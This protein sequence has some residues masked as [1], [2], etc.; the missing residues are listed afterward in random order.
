MLSFM[1]RPRGFYRDIVL[2]A[3]P[4][5]IQNLI[6]SSMSLL[7]TVMVGVLGELPLAAVALAN[8]PCF[9][10][11]FVIFGIQSGCSVLIS[12][13]WGKGD[14][15]AINRVLGMG[16]YSACSATLVFALATALFP[17]PFMSLFG[18]DQVVAE[19]AAEYIRIIGFSYFADSFV[20]IYIAAHRSMENPRLG[21]YILAA[22]VASNTFLN[23]ALIFGRFGAPAFGVAG[24]ALA[25]LLSRC[26]GLLLALGHFFLSFF[27]QDG[28]PVAGQESPNF[29]RPRGES[30]FFLL[31]FLERKRRGKRFRPDLAA[32]L[33][34]GGPMA[35]QFFRCSAPVVFNET[36]WGLGTALYATIMGH[37]EGS[38]EIL[39]AYAIAGNIERLCTVAIFAL[40]GTSAVIVGREIGAGKDRRTVYEV[41]ACLNLLTALTG[42]VLSLLLLV[43]LRLVIIPYLYPVFS[44][45][46]RSA[47]IATVML[48]VIFA[49]QT[50]RGF[51]TTN[52]VGV[53]RG[54]G[55]VRAAALIDTVPLWCVSLPLAALAGLA[56]RLDILWVY[57][58]I[59]TEGLAKLAL[60]VGRLRSG[61]WINDLTRK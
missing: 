46:P 15:D 8:I 60:G 52:I 57:L 11:T 41:G 10:A 18:N 23:W 44:L 35:L 2:L 28:V 24:A 17:L 19:L 27:Q 37:M 20:Q 53:L 5:L 32:L 29:R 16:L 31:L 12:Q 61:R 1:R 34:P 4:L 40:A 43:G 48:T 51:N 58:A 49:T 26:L 22:T 47:S 14:L 7:D 50:L 45:S 54:G 55:D 25:T 59:M 30:K 38:K 13:N 6:T 39:A 21:M 9:V 42:A 33:R 56:L 3:L 36:T